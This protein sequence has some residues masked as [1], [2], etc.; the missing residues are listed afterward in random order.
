[1]RLNCAKLYAKY[2]S[3]E[4]VSS[5]SSSGAICCCVSNFVRNARTANAC[6]ARAVRYVRE[7]ANRDFDCGDD[8][9]AV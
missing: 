5:A 8:I 9:R 1:M 7:C 3:S 6:A 4:T 2:V